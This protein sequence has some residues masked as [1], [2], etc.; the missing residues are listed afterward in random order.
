LLDA[1]R[2]QEAV[3]EIERALAVPA[4]DVR[5][6]VVTLRVLAAVRARIGDP[7]GAREALNEALEIAKVA[8][9]RTEVE[10]TKAA[11]IAL[12]GLSG[13]SG[14]GGMRRTR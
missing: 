2:V 6:R 14:M 11:L 7:G 5:S 3:V 9:Q 12:S 1:G 8:Q 10:T 13:M 4:E